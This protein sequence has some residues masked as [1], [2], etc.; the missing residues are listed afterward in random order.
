MRLFSVS[1]VALMIV[2]SA[3]FLS[4]APAVTP[5]IDPA[6][7]ANALALVAGALLLV[8]GRKR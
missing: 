7:G 5:E 3:T 4:A 2:G 6:M 8:R 1:A